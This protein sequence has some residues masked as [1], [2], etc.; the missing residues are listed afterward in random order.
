[1]LIIHDSRL[2]DEAIRNLQLYGECLSFHTEKITYEAIAGHP[3]IFFC[4]I[5]GDIV[6][7]LNTPTHFVDC[8]LARGFNIRKGENFVGGQKYNSTSYNAV[9]TDQYI[10][11]NRKYTDPSILNYLGRRIFMHVNQGYTRC[12]LFPLKNNNFITSDKGVEK[13]LCHNKINCCYISCEEILLPGFPYGF[14]GGCMGGYQNK[15]FIIGKLEYLSE[16]AKVYDF[17]RKLDYEIIELYDG[18][19]FD[20]GGLFFLP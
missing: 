15:I 9:V 6:V 8:L 19:L 20:G 13:T 10:I 12:S 5:D 18:M 1:M 11:H 3:D 16:G 7:A 2:P 17:L 14:L 4:P